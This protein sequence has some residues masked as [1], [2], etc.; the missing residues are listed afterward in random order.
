MKTC[1]MKQIFF[2]LLIIEFVQGSVQNA[3]QT[4]KSPMQLFRGK[5]NLG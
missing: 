5:M 4:A 3:D 1:C 2:L